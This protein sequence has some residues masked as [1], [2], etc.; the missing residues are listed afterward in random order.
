MLRVGSRRPACLRCCVGLMVMAWVVAPTVSAAEA[1]SPVSFRRD[2]RPILSNACYACHGPDEAQRQAG[3]RLDQHEAALAELDSGETAIVPGDS[4]ASALYQ[5]I[6]ESDASLRMPPEDHEIQLS[7]AQIELIRRWIDQGA[8]WQAHWSFVPPARLE[9]PDVEQSQWPRNAID[10][11]IL[12]RLES[13]GLQPSAEADRETLVRRLTFDLTGLPPTPAEVDAFLQD[14]SPEAYERLVDRLLNSPRY[15]E[16][17]ARYWLDAARY[18]DTHGLHLDNERAMWVY[19]NWVIDAFDANMPFDQFTIEQ[20]AGDLLPEPSQDQLIATGFNRC[21]VTTSEGGSIDEEYY[22]RYAVDRVET[23]STVFMGLTTGCAACHDHKFD[24]ISQREFYGLFAFFNSLTEKAMDGN[25]VAPPPVIKVP[26]DEQETQRAELNARRAELRA[27]LTAPDEALD[28]AQRAWES[29]V[30]GRYGD[31]WQPIEVSQATS[32]GGATLRS[33]DDGSWL[34]EGTNPSRDVYEIV[35]STTSAPIVAV[36]LEALTHESLPDQGPGRSS[37]SNFVLSEFELEAAPLASPEA[38]QPVAWSHARADH[39]Q[40]QGE[41][42]I[43]KAIDGVVDAS[44]GW[45]VSGY[46]RH[47]N[48]VAVFNPAAPIAFEGGAVLR[49]RLRHE[50]QFSQHAIGRFRLSVSTDLS[51]AP[52]S[53]A[54]WHQAGPFKNEAGGQVYDVTFGPEK[55]VDLT[56]TYGDEKL[57]WVERADL[58]DGVIHPL[59]GE[60]AATYFYRTIHAPSTRQVTLSL[61]SDDGIKVWLNEQ[62]VLDRNVERGVAENQDQ[63]SI[64]LQQGENRLLVKVSNVRSAGGFYFR[65]IEDEFGGEF[66]ELLPLLAVDPAERSAE[67]STRLREEYRRRHWD[68][69]QP[70]QDELASVDEKYVALEAAIPTTMVMKELDE[71]RPAYVLVRGE[72]DQKGDAVERMVPAALPPLPEGAPVNRLGLAQWLV[73]PSHPLT[74]R[75]TVNRFWQQFFGTGIVKTS[76]DFGAQGEWPSHPELLDW[77]AVDFVSS[78]WDIKACV[79]QMVMSA[80]YR[81]ASPVSETLQQRDPANRLLARGARFRLDAEVLRDNSLYLSGLLL[82]GDI[83]RGVKPYQPPGLWEAVGYTSS[84]TARFTRDDGDALYRRTIYT[85]WKRTA[86]PPAMLIFDAPSRESCAVRRPRTNTPLQALLLMND[87]QHV[88][89]ARQLAE[90]IVREGGRTTPERLRYGF[91]LVTSRWP[92]EQ[93]LT[94]LHETFDAQQAHY[95]ARAEAALELL[96]VGEARRDEALDAQALA[97]WTMIANLLLNLDETVTRG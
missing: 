10:H 31:Q 94:V 5:R 53:W 75:V 52:T 79:K 72:Y 84:N 90:R 46:E 77:L 39:S 82:E 16:H 7:P 44:N 9:P 47:E 35:A 55:G 86:P 78:G 61:G 17:M 13:E 92:S 66:A 76:E 70:L 73:D 21:N 3:L 32:S 85:F 50:S 14:D 24:P 36:R 56:A 91:R 23:T 57:A 19:R 34:A 89:A 40:A 69:W 20:L 37:N 8:D 88:E 18:G 22:V 74:A 25:A 48:R 62:V 1:P 33:L 68:R 4:A 95:A 93:E 67:Q 6:S 28:Q 58:S 96:S 11:F 45:A 29:E 83:G 65:A 43:A 54:A 63:V 51:T 60:Y 38:F 87:V 64:E 81:Q 15:G 59:E 30:A 97:A 41:Y 26:S 80:T 71:P 2:I 49:F 42:F 27:E 12:D